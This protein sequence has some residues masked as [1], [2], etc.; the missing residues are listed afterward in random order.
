MAVAGDC[1][2]SVCFAACMSGAVVS[3][4]ERRTLQDPEI[5]RKWSHTRSFCIVYFETTFDANPHANTVRTQLFRVAAP[6]L[7]AGRS[8]ARR[9]PAARHLQSLPGQG[10]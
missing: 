3:F 6:D 8:D 7:R 1:L 2:A 5:T 9:E 10:T 4:A